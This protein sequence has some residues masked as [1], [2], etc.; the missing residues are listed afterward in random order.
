[1]SNEFEALTSLWE[2]A[3]LLICEPQPLK[4]LL[5]PSSIKIQTVCISMRTNTVIFNM[6]SLPSSL[7]RR[8]RSWTAI[9]RV[10]NT[11]WRRTGINVQGTVNLRCDM[12]RALHCQ[13]VKE[14]MDQ[15]D[16]TT[17][18]CSNVT[19]HGQTRGTIQYVCETVCPNGQLCKKKPGPC[20]F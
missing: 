9:L 20:E 19:Q 10:L 11:F 7:N 2:E 13:A 15:I 14:A 12:E 5:N 6:R 8:S 4:P 1:M 16:Q 3:D 17:R 18:T